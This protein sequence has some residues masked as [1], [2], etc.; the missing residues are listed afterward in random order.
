MKYEN[1][2]SEITSLYTLVRKY[3]DKIKINLSYT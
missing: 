3:N 1:Y 2:N